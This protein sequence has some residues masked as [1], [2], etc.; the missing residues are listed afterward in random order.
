MHS[1]HFKLA[2][3]R[4][5]VF[6]VFPLH[7]HPLVAVE[8]HPHHPAWSSVRVPVTVVKEWSIR[9]MFSSCY[10]MSDILSPFYPIVH[11]FYPLLSRLCIVLLPPT[12]LPCFPFLLYLACF[13]PL[14]ASFLSAFVNVILYTF[15]AFSRAHRFLIS[16]AHLFTSFRPRLSRNLSS[17]ST[18]TSS[19]PTGIGIPVSILY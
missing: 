8:R 6:H 14:S 15:L 2:S 9:S 11:S 16:A 19:S 18:F 7:I 13:T 17:S 10:D 3:P 5:Y 4:Q 12:S 1:A